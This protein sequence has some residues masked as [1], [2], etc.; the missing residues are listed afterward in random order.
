MMSKVLLHGVLTLFPIGE[1]YCPDPSARTPILP[2]VALPRA[3]GGLF[4]APGPPS[5]R[6]VLALLA[7]NGRTPGDVVVGHHFVREQVTAPRLF[8]IV[9]P[10]RLWEVSYRVDVVGPDG[11]YSVYVDRSALVLAP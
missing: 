11:R 5:D 6:Y 8:P 1:W 10:A 7:T 2:P 9:G 3:V 4:P